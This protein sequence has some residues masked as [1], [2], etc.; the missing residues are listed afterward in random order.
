MKKGP[1]RLSLKKIEIMVLIVSILISSLGETGLQIQA[2]EGEDKEIN[3]ENVDQ[4]PPVL[5]EFSVEENERKITVVIEELAAE[6]QAEDVLLE[7]SADGTTWN[8]V[9]TEQAWEISENE[10]TLI[11]RFEGEEKKEAN[12]QFRVGYHAPSGNA[13]ILAE[14]MQN[15]IQCTE[16]TYQC[17]QKILIDRSAPVLSQLQFS[18]PVQMYDGTIGQPNGV[19]TQK[20]TGKETK[21]YYQEH[22]EVSFAVQDGY[23]KEESIELNIYYRDKHGKEWHLWEEETLFFKLPDQN[24]EKFYFELP[25]TEGEYYFE[26]FCMDHSNNEMVYSPD[27]KTTGIGENYL[28]GITKGIY[29]SPI[30]V[31]DSTKPEVKIL[32]RES[33]GE[34]YQGECL[35]TEI[36][37]AEENLNLN[38]TKIFLSAKDINGATINEACPKG[39]RYDAEQQIFQASWGELEEWIT[40]DEVKGQQKFLLETFADAYY[41][42]TVVVKDKG[43]KTAESQTAFCIDHTAPHISVVTQDGETFTNEVKIFSGILDEEKSDVKYSVANNGW[44]ANIINK[45]TFGYFAQEKIVVSVRVHDKVSGVSSLEVTCLQEEQEIMDYEISEPKRSKEDQSV[46]KYEIE[47]PANFKGT[48]KMRGTDCAQNSA[49]D[50]GAIGMVTETKKQHEKYAK[51]NVQVL[52]PY[53]KTPGYYAGNVTVKFDAEDGYSGFYEVDY[54]AGTYREHVVYPEGEEICLKVSKQH[55]IDADF[56]NC[57]HVKLGLSFFDNAG[58]V[59]MFPQEKLPTIHIDQTKPQIQVIYDNLKCENEKYYKAERKVQVIITERNFD[60]EDTRLVVTGPEVKITEW[61]HVAGSE[62]EADNDPY[63]THHTDQCSWCSNLYFSAD[64]EYRFTCS[65]TDLAGNEASYGCTDS[66]VIDKTLP[67]MKVTYD[68]HTV[69]NGR[70]Y[71]A[72]RTATIEIV[73]KNF[74]VSD[75]KIKLTAWDGEEE[76]TKPT[77]GAWSEEG[78]IHRTTIVYHDE[79]EFT[80]DISYTDLAGNQA[81]GEFFEKFVIDLT[82]PKIEITGLKDQSANN[83]MVAPVI[84]CMDSNYDKEKIWM[85]VV[86]YRNGLIERKESKIF[87]G[88]GVEIH[89]KDFEYDQKLDDMYRLRVN[90]SDLAG[91]TSETILA[92]SVNRFGSVFT[93]DESTERLAGAQGTYYTAKEQDIVVYETNVDT[94]KFREITL[95][96]NGKLKTLTEGEHYKAEKDENEYGWKRY[97]YHIGKENFTEEGIYIL[98]IY[99]E[100]LA[101]NK[102]D[103]QNKGKKIEFIVDK[104]APSVVVTGISDKKQYRERKKEITIDVEDNVCM[105][106]VEVALNG[107]TTTYDAMELAKTNGKIKLL[108][109][110]ANDWQTLNVKG[111]DGAGNVTE[112]EQLRFLITANIFVQFYRSQTLFYGSTAAAVVIAG[113]LYVHMKK[114]KKNMISS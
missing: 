46:V 80:F 8:P 51:T 112:I 104:T 58:H 90:A 23:L 29:Q 76:S 63:N 88:K 70:Y 2:K 111:Y 74:D 54:L 7:Y 22:A 55:I 93:F 103:N 83:G 25:S 108:L 16:G 84:F 57:N 106:C 30:F 35:Q 45:I 47:L 6:F 20:I 61:K 69:L 50:T 17:E 53:A 38:D 100:D 44:F 86:G 5:K 24:D 78:N 68:N 36:V 72:P 75:V 21:L 82:A 73:E 19:L 98:T 14:D 34:Y 4:V 65:T 15:V 33:P 31:K 28:E 49:K 97:A 11:V 109:D 114:R 59:E 79:G 52:T 105:S 12:Y 99:S 10:Q 87:S 1:L 48:I 67:Q 3:Y 102:S 95:N 101:K 77:V 56:N 66:F 39:F 27:I 26:L 18:A 96:L 43:E 113:Y 81:E 42:M 62:C 60:P 40:R 71:R 32:H 94:I 37:I 107:K 110:S 85:E 41:T 64:G 91:N 89:L 13:M 9:K 92:F